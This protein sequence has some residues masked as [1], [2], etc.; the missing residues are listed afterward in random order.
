MRAL[1]YPLRAELVERP[2]TILATEVPCAIWP[3]PGRV[4]QGGVHYDHEGEAAPEFGFD[5]SIANRVLRHDG[6]D[7]MI[8]TAT[9]HGYFPHV[10]LRLRRSAGSQN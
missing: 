6:Q 10:A 1:P 4:T 8:V 2:D 7:Y 3:T 9:S 5:L